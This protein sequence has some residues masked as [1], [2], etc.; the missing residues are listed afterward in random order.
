MGYNMSQVDAHFYIEYKNKKP[1]LLAAKRLFHPDMLNKFG[2]A[3]EYHNGKKIESC[4]SWVDTGEAN[5][6]S[7]IEGMLEAWGWKATNNDELNIVD[8]EFQREKIGQE[9]L[10]F[11]SIAEFVKPGSYI[12]MEGEDNA[13]W[14]WIFKNND[15]KEVFAETITRWP[16]DA[17]VE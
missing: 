16:E 3:G 13:K 11:R 10:L 12:E 5:Y 7:T 14:R 15:C 2:K 8:I 6:V 17:N 1:A 9:H 4:Y